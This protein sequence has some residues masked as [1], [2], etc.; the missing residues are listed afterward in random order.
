M[1]IYLLIFSILL[2]CS[3]PDKKSENK[4]PTILQKDCGCVD[5]FNTGIAFNE[6]QMVL[7]KNFVIRKENGQEYI[8]GNCA[9]AIR[10]YIVNEEGYEIEKEEL[11]CVSKNK[12]A[13]KLSDSTLYSFYMSGAEPITGAT[14]KNHL[15][16]VLKNDPKTILNIKFIPEKKIAVLITKAYFPE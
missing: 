5:D 12:I 13:I 8:E 9:E 4:Q 15:L 7:L 1:K 16:T 6:T 11:S 2:N 3:K 14:A 10:M